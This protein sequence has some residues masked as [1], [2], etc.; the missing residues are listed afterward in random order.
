MALGWIPLRSTT[1]TGRAHP[2]LLRLP[3]CYPVQADTWLLATAM[4][5]LDLVR[6][7]DV[8]DLCT[9]TG[10]LAVVART[11]GAATVTAVDISVRSTLNATLNLR[12][13]GMAAEVV[14]GDLYSALSPS[15][16]FDLIVSNPPY[17][18]SVPGPLPR[19]TVA[20]CWDAGPGGRVLLDPICDQAF[21]RLRPGGSLLLVQSEVSGER[22]SLRRLTNAGLDADVVRRSEVPFGPVMR[23]KA[24]AMRSAGLLRTG[25]DVEEIM[26]IRA[27]RP[28]A[29]G[30]GVRAH[31]RAGRTEERLP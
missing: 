23:S 7:R 27:V 11:E 29:P 5:E 26:V 9:G 10:A 22:E 8:L 6:E 4:V 17:V 16:T 14:R 24:A 1:Y 31:R 19:H 18:P 12:G 25:Q 2:R 28:G 30:A 20:R 3:G 13:R 21:D 15:R